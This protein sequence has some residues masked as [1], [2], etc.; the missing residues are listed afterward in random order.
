[1]SVLERV[2]G[3]WVCVDE[4]ADPAVSGLMLGGNE[5]EA[6]ISGKVRR[7]IVRSDDKIIFSLSSAVSVQC[8]QLHKASGGGCLIRHIQR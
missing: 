8:F 1:M 3:S 6:P 5:A 2:S 7:T 4:K